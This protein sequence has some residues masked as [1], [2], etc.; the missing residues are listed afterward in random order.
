MLERQLNT[1]SVNGDD[2]DICVESAVVKQSILVE[3]LMTS[4][5]RIF[6]YGALRQE[7]YLKDVCAPFSNK[8]KGQIKF[9]HVWLKLTYHSRIKCQISFGNCS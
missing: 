7:A 6:E 9:E 3:N 4:V 1:G 8:L 2:L 5:E